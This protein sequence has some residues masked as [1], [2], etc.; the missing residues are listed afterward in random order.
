MEF[1]RDGEVASNIDTRLR[2]LAHNSNSVP[3]LSILLTSLLVLL[4]GSACPGQTPGIAEMIPPSSP[5]SSAD[6]D[7]A[8]LVSEL[9]RAII[10]LKRGLDENWQNRDQYLSAFEKTPNV[11]STGRSAT[12][13]KRYVECTI[14]RHLRT[15]QMW[16]EG[17]PIE[18]EVRQTI[19]ELIELRNDGE[20][21]SAPDKRSTELHLPPRISR[22]HPTTVVSAGVAAAM[23]ETK[24]D[25]IYPPEAL[26][27]N[28]SGTVILHAVIG[29][30]GHIAALQIVSGPAPLYQAA[31]NAA[32]Q[33]TYR[34]Y[35]LNNRP[36]EVETTINIAFNPHR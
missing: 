9:N 12:A 14:D 22:A 5:C 4:A 32:R 30:D 10:I 19:T 34:P 15:H 18:S 16:D 27:H 7:P 29:K 31:L 13:A 21:A 20:Q 36:V 24:I 23:L 28:I 1:R 26:K 8:S 11:D 25:P 17:L 6:P 2:V 33:W 3:C 35:Q